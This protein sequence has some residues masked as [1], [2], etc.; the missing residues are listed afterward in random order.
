[1]V[2]L[3][4]A[5]LKAGLESLGPAKELLERKRIEEEQSMKEKR[6][7]SSPKSYTPEE[8]NLLLAQMQ[9]DADARRNALERS[10][11]IQ[12]QQQER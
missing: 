5:S 3:Q 7:G 12:N 8:R 1:M 9:A 6:M 10:I 4:N 2:G 11:S